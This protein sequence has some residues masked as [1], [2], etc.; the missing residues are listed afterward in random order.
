PAVQKVREAAARTQCINN[1]KQLGLG[2]HNYHD[3]WQRFPYLR[4]GGG[5][6]RHSWAMIILPYIE[7]SAIFNKFREPITGVSMTDG[8]NNLTATDPQIVD[9][10]QS[11]VA[12]FFCPARR[13]APNT[14]PIT[15]GSTVLGMP[16]DYAACVGDTGTAPTTGVF[17]SVNSNHMESGV[18]LKEIQ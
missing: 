14:S 11:Q 6:N 9:V 7:Q 3:A 16:G 17:R 2:V 5:Q 10:R 13:T 18:R 4:S 12:T 1:L 15:A 8:F